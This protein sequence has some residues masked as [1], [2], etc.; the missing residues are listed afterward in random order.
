MNLDSIDQIKQADPEQALTVISN[1]ADQLSFQPE[2][3]H[4]VGEHSEVR[5][6]IISGM[7]GSCL[8]GLI[9]Q[10]WL[11][12]DYRLSV[13]LEVSRDYQLPAYTDS[14]SLVICVSVSG[15]TEETISY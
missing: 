6:I 11:D 2:L 8:A 15:N 13:P 10:T 7:G 5:N 3:H 4:E 9:C 12:H 14:H 1:S